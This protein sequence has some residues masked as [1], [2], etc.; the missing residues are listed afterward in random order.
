MAMANHMANRDPKNLE[1]SS[2]IMFHCSGHNR[3]K[4]IS[5][6]LEPNGASK[7]S[8]HAKRIS[9]CRCQQRLLGTESASGSSGEVIDETWELK[10]CPW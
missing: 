3:G 2:S 10:A 8:G 6:E 7:R 5:E 4:R 1:G 9:A